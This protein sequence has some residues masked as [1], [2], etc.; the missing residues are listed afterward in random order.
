[1]A[2]QISHEKWQILGKGQPLLSIGTFCCELCRSGWTDRFAV[3]VVDLGGPKQEQVN[4]IGQVA[5]IYPTTLCG[6]LWKNGWTDR[7]A[8][9]VVDSGG[10]KE[11]KFSCIHQGAPICSHGRACWRHLMNMIEPSGCG[12]AVLCPIT[13]TTCYVCVSLN[14]IKYSFY[15][16]IWS[17]NSI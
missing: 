7:F 11:H 14:Y 15:V 4:R 6:K 17:V 2:V 5:P 12:N 3:W 9:C 1:M 16:V 10:P 13:L 8:I